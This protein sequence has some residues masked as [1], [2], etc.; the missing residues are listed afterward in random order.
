MSWDNG[1]YQMI[2]GKKGQMKS[3]IKM[4]VFNPQS[5]AAQS[6]TFCSQLTGH[7]VQQVQHLQVNY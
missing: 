1:A 7:D 4:C 3:E 2:R 6:P 5:L